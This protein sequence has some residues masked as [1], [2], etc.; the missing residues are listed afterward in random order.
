MSFLID[1]LLAFSRTGRAEINA[2]EIDSRAMVDQVIQ[3]LQ[4]D[5]QGPR[6]HVEDRNVAGGGGGSIF[7]PPRLDESAFQR[8]EIH[9]PPGRSGDRN[10]LLRLGRQTWRARRKRSFWC[11]ITGLVFDMKYA[12]TLFGVFQR[13]HSSQDF[14]GTGIGLANVHRTIL[15]HGGRIWAESRPNEGRQLLFLAAAGLGRGGGVKQIALNGAAYG[16]K[17]IVIG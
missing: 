11:A 10:R 7:A 6:H 15:R 16:I 9:P 14:E 5:I 17:R 12:A 1:D 13:F 2:V 3:E 4:G 8:P